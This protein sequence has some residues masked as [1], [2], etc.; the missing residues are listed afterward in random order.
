VQDD[1]LR[2]EKYLAEP[3]G[4]AATAVAANGTVKGQ[5]PLQQLLCRA[6]A[7][8]VNAD[9]VLHGTLSDTGLAAGP[10]A[11]RDV[12]R[13]V[14]YENRI[15]VAW[16]TMQEIHSILETNATVTTEHFLGVWGVAYDLHP[17]NAVGER[18]Q[19]LRLADGSQPDAQQ[20]VAVA[21]NSHT[22][23]GGGGRFLLVPKIVASPDARFVLTTNDTRTAVAD[24]IRAHSPLRNENPPLVKVVE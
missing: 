6:I 2:A 1:L 14:P 7:E 3:V 17:T 8:K 21:M 20:R 18:V 24:Y 19:N 5:S 23:A 13:I 9:V 10:L 12:W 4:S 15:G 16:L 22:L 11:E